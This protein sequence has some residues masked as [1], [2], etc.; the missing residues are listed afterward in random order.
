MVSEVLFLTISAAIHGFDTHNYVFPT[1]KGNVIISATKLS[2]GC[3]YR[4]QQLLGLIEVTLRAHRSAAGTVENDTPACSGYIWNWALKTGAIKKCTIT[5]LGSL[6][7]A[8]CADA[9]ITGTLEK[10]THTVGAR[11]VGARIRCTR[12]GAE[13]PTERRCSIEV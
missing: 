8:S 2:A 3:L 9:L 7:A 12:I 5:N 13:Q 11:G 4:A 10:C 6:T 1:E